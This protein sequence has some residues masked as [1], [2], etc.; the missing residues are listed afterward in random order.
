MWIF[1]Q[2]GPVSLFPGL[3]HF[4]S[5]VC[6][7]YNTRRRKSTKNREGLVSSITWVTSGGCD[8]DVRGR[9]LTA[10]SRK[11]R[12][13]WVIIHETWKVQSKSTLSSSD[14]TT[15][16]LT[17]LRSN[18]HECV[19]GC[20]TGWSPPPYIIIASTLRPPD[21]THVMDETRP[22]L[23]FALF[24]FRV[25]YWTQTEEQKRGRPGNKARGPVL[26]IEPGKF[27]WTFYRQLLVSHSI[28]SLTNDM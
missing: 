11:N 15:M 13:E 6:V 22:S 18:S 21:V 26:V 3:P 24:H 19:H 27:A 17:M 5:S 14:C 28:K 4:R 25:L 16:I 12:Y 23:F 9:G 7:Q 20:Y 10:R 2:G 8:N 1:D